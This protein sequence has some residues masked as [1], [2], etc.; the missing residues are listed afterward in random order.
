MDTWNSIEVGFGAK[1]GTQ[2]MDQ[3]WD[4]DCVIITHVGTDLNCESDAGIPSL[5]S[6][7]Q[8]VARRS[9]VQL[10]SLCKVMGCR[11]G[12]DP[13][14]TP[15]CTQYSAIPSQGPVSL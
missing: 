2:K 1:N 3:G 5:E 14:L 9:S 15:G 7:L 4:W 12:R 11:Q 10:C 6:C 8:A 13:V